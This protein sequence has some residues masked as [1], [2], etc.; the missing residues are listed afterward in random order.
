MNYLNTVQ[1]ELW[2]DYCMP[3]APSGD[4]TVYNDLTKG[5]TTSCRVTPFNNDICWAN[6]EFEARTNQNGVAV[7][8][9]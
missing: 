8:T 7:L 9:G 5:R 3:L 2:C 4:Q 6:D 1:S